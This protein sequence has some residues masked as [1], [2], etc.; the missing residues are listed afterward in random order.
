MT[1]TPL[2]R[3]VLKSSLESVQLLLAAGAGVNVCNEY[4]VTALMCSLGSTHHDATSAPHMVEA[5][6]AAG[7]DVAAR[8]NDGDTVL[9][10]LA[11]NSHAQ[12]WAAAVARLLLGAGADGRAVNTAGATPAQCVRIGAHGGE[13]HRLLLE[14]AEV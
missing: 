3:A 14:A 10:K 6:L 12:P 1:V 7:A 11:I 8:D 9:H 4:G 13:L 5:L 2:I